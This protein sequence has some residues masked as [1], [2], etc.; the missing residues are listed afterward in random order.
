MDGPE[1][2][3]ELNRVNKCG[4]FFTLVVQKDAVQM[5]G[6]ARTGRHSTTATRYLRPSASGGAPHRALKG[7]ADAVSSW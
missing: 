7:A 4:I 6:T 3:L 2:P 5:G 1:A